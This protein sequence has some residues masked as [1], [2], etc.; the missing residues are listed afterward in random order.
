MARPS[1]LRFPPAHFAIALVLALAWGLANA[2]GWKLGHDAV[3]MARSSAHFVYQALL[4]M[5]LLVVTLGVADAYARDER[6]VA[7]YA[8][9]AVGAAVGGE[10]LFSATA[11]LLGVSSCG[12]NM[13]RWRPGM[14]TANMLPDALLICGF[15]TAGYR[16]RRSSSQRLARLNAREIERAQLQRRTQ[17]SRLQAA[18]ACIEPQFLFDTL[19]AVSRMHGADPRNAARLVDELIIYLR[20]ALPHLRESTSTVAKEAELAQAWINIRR[21]RHGRG[22]MLDLDLG[23]NAGTAQMPPM[24]LLPLVTCALE[25][26]AD[27]GE[28]MRVRARLAGGRL[29]LEVATSGAPCPPA[30]LD[31]LRERL[32]TLYGDDATLSIRG[33]RD[34]GGTFVTLDL[35]HDGDHRD[36]R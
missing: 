34:D 9:A 25:G 21:L 8:L 32:H 26:T 30:T 13:D 17:E 23:A 27:D 3:D 2:L 4:P 22:P 15:I 14:R 28:A 29:R 19:D 35:P 11:P 33:G 24:L 6:A 10:L 20:A 5:L 36:P 16:Y 1:G 12:C 18:Q 7:P 31:G